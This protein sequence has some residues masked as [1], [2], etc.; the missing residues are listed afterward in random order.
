LGL[1]RLTRFVTVI[2]PDA[3]PVRD[4]CAGLESSRNFVRVTFQKASRG[5]RVWAFVLLVW[6]GYSREF[7]VLDGVPVGVGLSNRFWESY[8]AA[9]PDSPA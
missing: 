4:L 1:G 3:V 6:V 9:R 7:T 5:D 8:T 2:R